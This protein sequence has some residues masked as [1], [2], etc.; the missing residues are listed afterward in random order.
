MVSTAH[1]SKGLEWDNVKIGDDFF[2]PREDKNTGTTIM[3][4]DDE[5]RLAYVAVTR[6]RKK[7][8]P[9]S[10]E[11]VY[12]YTD[13]NGGD[14]SSTTEPEETDPLRDRIKDTGLWPVLMRGPADPMPVP[15]S[16]SAPKPDGS[17]ARAGITQQRRMRFPA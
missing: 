11:Y 12:S 1:K 8:D 10:L 2:G 15:L 14:P 4:N 9:G 5:H 17:R 13:E 6:A 3:P 7:L 16:A